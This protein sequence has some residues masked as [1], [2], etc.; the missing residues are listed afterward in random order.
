MEMIQKELW[1]KDIWY[2]I[3]MGDY[4][5]CNGIVYD[6]NTGEIICSTVELFV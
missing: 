5:E 3:Q 2:H 1:K 4:V 6:Y